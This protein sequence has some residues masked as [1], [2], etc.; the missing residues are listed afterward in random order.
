[1]V[2]LSL[3][4]PKGA[5]VQLAHPL[6]LSTLAVPTVIF[7]CSLSQQRGPKSARIYSETRRAALDAGIIKPLS[8]ATTTGEDE[9][10]GGR[11]LLQPEDEETGGPRPT[12][13]RSENGGQTILV[14]RHGFSN[15]GRVYKE[16]KAL[17]EGWDEE[18][19]SWR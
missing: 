2:S 1:M 12:A 18:A 15:F 4:L 5:R 16:D 9:G 14:L 10:Q 13:R 8:P 6:H 3:S 11:A 7:H 19:W 17:V